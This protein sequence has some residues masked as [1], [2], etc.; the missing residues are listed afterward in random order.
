M[1]NLV[2]ILKYIMQKLITSTILFIFIGLTHITHAQQS[3][4]SG[5][6]STE[7]MNLHFQ[8]HP[9]LKQ[10]FDNYQALVNSNQNASK[11]IATTNYTIPVVFH[12]LHLN[13]SEN[14]SDA[15]VMDAVDALNIDYAKQNADTANT[16]AVFKSI[17]K[18]TTIRFELAKR[19]PNGVCTNGIIRHFDPDANW[20][21]QSPTLYQHTWDP[22]MYLNVYVVKSITMSN[23]FSAA[24]YTYL[25]GSWSFGAPQDAIV[26]LHTYTGTMGTSNTSH[27]HV[28]THEVG[29]WLNLLHVFGW[30]SCAVDCNND[31]F[32]FDTPNTP[33]YLSCPTVYDNCTPGVPENYQ[34]FM[35]YSYC[36]TMFTNGQVLRMQNAVQSGV[37]GRNNLGSTSN[38][39]ATGINPAIQCAPVAIFKSNKRTI[40]QGQSITYTDQSNVGTPTTWNWIFAGGTPSVSSVQNP[41]VTYNNPGT[42]SVQLISGNTIG[43]SQPEIKNE[44]ITVFGPATSNTLTEGFETSTIPNNIWSVQN[45]SSSNTNWQQTSFAA[46][47]GN[48]SA[49]VSENVA[50]IST[51]DLFSPAYDFSLIPNVALTFKWAGAERDISSQNS[52]DVFSLYYSTNCGVTWTP[53]IVKQIRT[54]TAGI[55]VVN[56][57]FQ[58]TSSEFNQEIVV[59]GTLASATNVIFR[60]RLVTESGS[61]NNFYLDDINLT[62]VTSLKDNSSFLSSLSL[63]P[64][65]ANEKLFVNFNL[66]ENKTIALNI[67]DMLGKNVKTISSQNYTAG[68]QQIEIPVNGIERGVY[69]LA[70]D[71]EGQISNHK[72]I[73]D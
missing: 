21:D 24:G 2:T 60:Y 64:N 54:T 44:Y 39:M 8:K 34:N 12:I 5:C 16:L 4:M 30:S 43:N 27:S 26:M 13:G 69:I 45:I 57:N 22:S 47:S 49:F 55:T 1:F 9:E 14:I 23:G 25:P 28:L 35:D 70:L 59:I 6:M 73:I 33:G 31:D 3:P 32:V 7:A 42:Y 17:A 37:V 65:P 40:C 56:G 52:Y 18:P 50:P 61:S 53:R 58:P 71:I 11:S 72:I 20:D 63:Y 62:S 51:V 67:Y 19:D 41:T 46:A 38:L 29:H 15:Q 10:Q 36:S 68:N 48:K 66:N